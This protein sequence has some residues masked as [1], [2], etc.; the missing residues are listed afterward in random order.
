MAEYL[1][2]PRC[3]NQF[4]KK[5]SFCRTCG[6]SLSGIVEIVSGEAPPN[7]GSLVSRPNPRAIR[8]GIGL[9]IFGLFLG[10]LHG[11]LRELGLYPESYGK[12]VFLAF[13]ASGMLCFVLAFLFPTTVY[14]KQTEAL[15]ASGSS[16]PLSLDT[17]DLTIDRLNPAPAASAFEVPFKAR[18]DNDSGVPSVTEHTTR[19]L[20]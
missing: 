7:K 3:G 5:T 10:L 19:K 1:H 15:A 18:E 11:A 12:I 16:E 8:L 9:F 4:S 20:S 2:C 14:K 13:C 6:L 17:S